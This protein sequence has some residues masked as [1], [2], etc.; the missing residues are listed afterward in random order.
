MKL[1]PFKKR[2]ELLGRIQI[3]DGKII[4]EDGLNPCNPV[5]CKGSDLPTVSEPEESPDLS[6]FSNPEA[7]PDSTS[8]PE[9]C[10]AE[11]LRLDT[12]PEPSPAS[13]ESPVFYPPAEPQYHPSFLID[14]AD[15]GDTG[16][17]LDYL[18]SLGRKERTRQEY[19]IDLRAWKRELAGAWPDSGLVQ[20][21]TSGLKPH[22]AH[23]LITAL[24]SYSRYRNLHGDPRLSV[25][26]ATAINL[27]PVKI[28]PPK[29]PEVLTRQQI[30]MYRTT[31]RELCGDGNRVGIWIGLTLLCVKSAEMKSAWPDGDRS[32]LIGTDPPRTIEAPDWLVRAMTEIDRAE[33]ER[34]NNA[35]RKGLERYGTSP[36][37]LYMSAVAYHSGNGG[38]CGKS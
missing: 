18:E 7:E 31:A 37:I 34:T 22:R 28:P 29:K 38:G 16:L 35:I 26:F 8:E 1:W 24:K 2:E 23:R 13:A 21:I 11:N 10:R 20:Q 4:S 36:R 3:R 30:R 12:L 6:T 5:I 19:L 32:I 17:F 9:P 27:K 25:M 33:W 14:E 15:G